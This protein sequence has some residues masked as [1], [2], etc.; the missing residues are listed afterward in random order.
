Q[1]NGTYKYESRRKEIQQA[2]EPLK[3]A[4]AGLILPL[5]TREPGSFAYLIRN[6]AGLE[7]NRIEYSVAG[8]ANLT[9]SLDRNAELELR[10]SKKEFAPGEDIELS[11]KAPYLGAGLITIERDRV[12][13]AQWF[14]ASTSASVQHIKL[15]A[16]FEGNGYVSVQFTRELGSEEIFASPLSY[17]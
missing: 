12:Y 13:A 2:E 1:A 8:N 10:L 11:I 4:A 9:R 14:K 5:N 3:I 6:G 16:D 7:L 17:G 15:P